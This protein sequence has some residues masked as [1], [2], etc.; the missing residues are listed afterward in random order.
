MEFQ[1]SPAYSAPAREQPYAAPS[2][3]DRDPAYAETPDIVTD[4]DAFD[5]YEFPDE[6]APTPVIIVPRA[7]RPF[8]RH[9]FTSSF[10]VGSE[11]TKVVGNAYE[12]R[13]LRLQ[14]TGE[15]STILLST[16]PSPIRATSYVLPPG[17]Y[18]ETTTTD[19]I[20]AMTLAATY[21]EDVADKQALLTLLASAA[22]TVNGTGPALTLPDTAGPVR[23]ELNVTAM[24]GTSPTLDVAVQD[25]YADGWAD[26]AAFPQVTAVGRYRLNID[27]PYFQ[28]WR[29]DW[30]L[31]GTS[32]SFTF[33]VI[34]STTVDEPLNPAGDL[35]NTTSTLAIIDERE[36]PT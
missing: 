33:E 27:R 34:L 22:R 16:N 31:G 1:P 12:D 35:T 15:R 19:V 28:D 23:A 21:N 14:N 20:Y 30:T 2:A 7:P 5:P 26:L 17:E 29:A 11:I 36:Y 3:K 8:A 18:I 25:A 24:G 13:K 10:L 9:I 6:V 4:R 32:P